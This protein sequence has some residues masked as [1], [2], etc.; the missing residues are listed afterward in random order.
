V[1]N[2]GLGLSEPGGESVT[3]FCAHSN[4]LPDLQ[5]K[6]KKKKKKRR[7]IPY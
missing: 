4:K 1:G 7:E 2:C 3:G 6:K 5:K